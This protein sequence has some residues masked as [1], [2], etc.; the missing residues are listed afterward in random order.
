MCIRDRSAT[1]IG[2]DVTVDVVLSAVDGRNL[3]FDVH[4]WQD[5]NVTIGRGV[6]SR[7]LV[8]R[9]KFLGC[10]YGAE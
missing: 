10:L 4:A 5:E 3:R 2:T 9:E 7:V 1:A 8:D 6:I